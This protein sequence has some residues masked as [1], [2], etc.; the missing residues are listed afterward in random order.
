MSVDNEQCEIKHK[1]V[2]IIF[3]VNI[4]TVMIQNIV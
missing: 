4:N 3:I 2:S 1:S